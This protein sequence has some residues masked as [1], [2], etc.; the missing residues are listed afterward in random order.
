MRIGQLKIKL[1]LQAVFPTVFTMV[2]MLLF[3]LKPAQAQELET[4]EKAFK[5][6]FPQV[7]TPMWI[8]KVDNSYEATFKLN[9]AFVSSVYTEDGKWLFNKAPIDTAQ[10]P[11]TVKTTI[12]KKYSD[13]KITFAEKLETADKGIQYQILFRSGA[14]KIEATFDYQGNFIK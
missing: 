13:A 2:I 12:T 10:I 5:E 1:K 7:S 6:K 3:L 9:G 11:V 8:K 4:Y 14:K